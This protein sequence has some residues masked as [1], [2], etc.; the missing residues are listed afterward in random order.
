VFPHQV[1]ERPRQRQKPSTSGVTVRDE[2]VTADRLTGDLTVPDEN[3]TGIL[4]TAD[5][6]TV[7]LNGF[8][9]IGPVDCTATSFP[10]VTT[11]SASGTGD[12][13][14]GLGPG[15]RAPENIVVVNGT[16]RGMG[17]SG[18]T[19]IFGRVERVRVESNGL[20]GIGIPITFDPAMF[21]APGSAIV[22]CRAVRNGFKGITAGQNGLV[23]GNVANLNGDVGIGCQDC[24]VSNNTAISNEGDGIV[25]GTNCVIIGNTANSNGGNGIAGGGVVRNNTANFNTGFGLDISGGGYAGNVLND[26]VGGTVDPGGAVLG[27]NVCDQNLT[28]P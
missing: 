9:I 15:G 24:T 3:T 21:P 13:I 8:A 18:I 20:T 28:C 22:D 17:A 10:P 11:C 26:N 1:R 23:T 12:G 19:F 27:P 2:F 4:I 5:D 7:D 25:C 6:V 16:V 14:A